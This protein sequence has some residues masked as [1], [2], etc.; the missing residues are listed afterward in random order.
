MQRGACGGEGRVGAWLKSHNEGLSQSLVEG[1]AGVDGCQDET[2]GQK[3]SDEVC[4]AMY[5]WYVQEDRY[6]HI[7]TPTV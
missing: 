2:R 3:G 5:C 6:M 1:A 4:M 7:Y